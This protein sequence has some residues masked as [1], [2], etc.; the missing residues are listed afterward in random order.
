MCICIFPIAG[1]A[2]GEEEGEAAVAEVH[3]VEGPV[4]R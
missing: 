2:V 1:D 4:F 3:D